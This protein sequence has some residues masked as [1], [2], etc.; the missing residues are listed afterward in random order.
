MY[1][2]IGIFIAVALVAL[3]ALVIVVVGS[4]E[5]GSFF[6]E[7]G[8]LEW[9]QFSLVAASGLVL[10]TRARVSRSYPDAFLLLGTLALLAAVR[11]LDRF[12]DHLAF[13]QAHKFVS[14]GILAV[15]GYSAWAH[16]ARL[17][18][19]LRAFSGTPPFF[20]MLAGSVAVVLFA[21]LLGQHELWRAILDGSDG[22]IAKRAVEEIFETIGYAFIFFGSLET[23]F[24]EPVRESTRAVLRRGDPAASDRPAV[25]TYEGAER[26]RKSLSG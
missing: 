26:P 13:D 7:D 5:P 18:G 12:F 2:R 3:Q 17:V 23:L 4:V 6:R 10:L 11:E 21:Q 1:I 25:A 14:A 24:L 15:Y 22:R 20:W 9:I 8:I 19:Q 16:R